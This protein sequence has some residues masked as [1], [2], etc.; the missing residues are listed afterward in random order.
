MSSF[1]I[2][3]RRTPFQTSLVCRRLWVLNACSA[4]KRT[5][6]GEGGGGGCGRGQGDVV[7]V[8]KDD[9]TLQ[10]YN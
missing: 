1:Y 8:S 3:V 5:K 6:W 9:N 4:D 10:C 7:S 2:L